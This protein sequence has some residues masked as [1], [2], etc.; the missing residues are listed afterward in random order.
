MDAPH[1]ID[2][3]HHAITPAIGSL[4]TEIGAPNP[5]QWSL[6]DASR[7]M[8]VNAIEFAVLSNAIPYDL[9]EQPTTAA[10]FVRGANESVAELARAQ[11]GRFGQFPALPLPWI[12]LALTELDYVFDDL[13][14]DGVTLLPHVGDHYLGDPVF[15]PLLAELD[16]RAAVVFVHPTHL[17]GQ[18]SSTVPAVLADYLL[19]TTRAAVGIMRALVPDRFP[20]ISFVLAHAGGFLPYAATRIEVLSHAFH[21]V[22]PLT[23][24]NYLRRFYYDL[25]LAVPSALPSL[26]SV[27]AADRILYGTDW[28]AVPSSAVSTMT[29]ALRGS[30]MIPADLRVAIGRNNALRLLPRLCARLAGTSGGLPPEALRTDGQAD[31]GQQDRHTGADE[32]AGRVER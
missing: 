5:F 1:W 10:R 21:G 6:G 9:F 28:C 26:L 3:H 23:T 25:A 4:L 15:D 31:D 2:V 14:A 7:V 20:R 29:R 30:A 8:A 18:R 19:D 16:R 11:P 13:G 22:D 27:A 17:A 24:E 32:E 12:D